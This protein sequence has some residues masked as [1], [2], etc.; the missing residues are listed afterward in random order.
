MDEENIIFEERDLERVLH[1]VSGLDDD[2]E[3]LICKAILIKQKARGEL[4]EDDVDDLLRDLQGQRL[5]DSYLRR[6]ILRKLYGG[7]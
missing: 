6:D 4:D 3:E 7:K 5:I 1:R 2:Q